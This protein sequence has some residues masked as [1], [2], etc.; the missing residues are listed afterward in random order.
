MFLSMVYCMHSVS[1]VW[2]YVMYVCRWIVIA[3]W[4]IRVCMYG[5]ARCGGVVWRIAW[6][7]SNVYVIE[8]FGGILFEIWTV[9]RR[10]VRC[11]LRE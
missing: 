1:V 9:F 5:Q 6:A 3:L 4:I 11:S 7:L 10:W 8:S 2:V